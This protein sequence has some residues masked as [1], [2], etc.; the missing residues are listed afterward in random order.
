MS[1]TAIDIL[2][3]LVAHVNA[4]WSWISTGSSGVPPL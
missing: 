2:N 4:F 3:V 1:S